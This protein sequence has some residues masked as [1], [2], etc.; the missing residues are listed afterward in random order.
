MELWVNPILAEKSPYFKLWSLNLYYN[1]VNFPCKIKPLKMI[2]EIFHWYFLLNSFCISFMFLNPKSINCKNFFFFI[3]ITLK[4]K[5]NIITYK[6]YM[7]F[8]FLGDS[9]KITS[10]WPQDLV[11]ST[12]DYLFN[13]YAF[14]VT[15]RYWSWPISGL[16]TYTL[17]AHALASFQPDSS[18]YWALRNWPLSCD[19]CW[20]LFLVCLIGFAVYLDHFLETY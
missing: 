16:M 7:N 13:F 9:L 2:N 8:E 17:F 1:L 12:Q 14:S 15:W 19:I 4:S 11:E 5:S 10:R 20:E 6:I 3:L 18:E